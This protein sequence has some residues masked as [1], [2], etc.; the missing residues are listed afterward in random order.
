MLERAAELKAVLTESIIR[1]KPRGEDDFG[2][3][4]E[5]RYYNAL[6]FLYVV[7]LKPYSQR[8][9]HIPTDPV[10]R[11]ALEWFRVHVPERTLYNWQ[12]AATRLIAQDLRNGSIK[13]G[14]AT[15]APTGRKSTKKSVSAN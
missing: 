13:R 11:K 15:E 1:L 8:T 9:Q 12:N 5:W 3:S 4:D 7:G 10:T 14:V 2:T 6:Y